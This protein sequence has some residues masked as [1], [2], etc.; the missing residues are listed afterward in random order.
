MK[1]SSN[2]SDRRHQGLF[3]AVTLSVRCQEEMLFFHA[4]EQLRGG[5]LR[6][7]SLAIARQR[8]RPARRVVCG[9]PRLTFPTRPQAFLRPLALLYYSL[10]VHAVTAHTLTHVC[11]CST[12]RNRCTQAHAALSQ[13]GPHRLVMDPAATHLFPGVLVNALLVKPDK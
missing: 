8:R 3:P 7:F 13:T 2:H 1:S 12:P 9:Q 4:A 11:T 5:G 6:S 10:P